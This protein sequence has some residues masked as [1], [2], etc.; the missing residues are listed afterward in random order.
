MYRQWSV[1]FLKAIEVVFLSLRVANFPL[2]FH[3]LLIMSLFEFSTSLILI[4]LQGAYLISNS[5]HLAYL[6]SSASVS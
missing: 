6:V 3:C 5:P 2:K 1:E 4:K